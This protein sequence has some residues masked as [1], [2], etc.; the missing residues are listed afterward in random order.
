MLSRYKERLRSADLLARDLT[1]TKCLP[2]LIRLTEASLAMAEQD[3]QEF[4]GLFGEPIPE[5]LAT[6][7]HQ[8]ANCWFALRTTLAAAKGA[9]LTPQEYDRL[10][11]QLRRKITTLTKII[12]LEAEIMQSPLRKTFLEQLKSLREA[13]S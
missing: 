10:L 13:R 6:A 9:S 12:A 7:V 4:S 8:E 11:P 1:V 5:H 2:S 3:Q